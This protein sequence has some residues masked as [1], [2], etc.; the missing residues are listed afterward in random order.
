MV[1]RLLFSCSI[2][3]LSFS[4][5]ATEVK[6]SSDAKVSPVDIVNQMEANGSHTGFRRNH[7]KGLCVEGIFK[8]TKEAR[9]LSSSNIFSA[10]A[11]EVIGRFSNPGPNPNSPDNAPMP[12]GFAMQFRP[13]KGASSNMSMLD[14]PLFSVNTPEAFLEL[15][16][17]KTP[18]QVAAFKEKHPE[19]AP[20]FAFIKDFGVPQSYATVD[21][22]S[23]H[24]FKFTNKK[25]KE[26]FVR[27][28]FISD[29]GNHFL[30]VDQAK[31]KSA[32]FL[33]KTL[34]EE[35]KKG[36]VTWKMEAILAKDGDSLTD[37]TVE[38]KGEHKKV[39]LGM[40][41]IKKTSGNGSSNCDL[42]NYDPNNLAEGIAPSDDQILR[43]RSPAYAI[44]FGK[45]VSE[46]A[47][48]KQ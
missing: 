20:F 13:S 12:R 8:G 45:R 24:A 36:P 9:E 47:Q 19:S 5:F 30:T 39:Q 26:Q 46:Q 37:P 43:F 29:Q 41:T 34:E 42:I 31:A 23:L 6:S 32:D 22:H 7:A 28:N 25:G 44:S 17:V 2:G 3:L 4:V 11:V 48:K 33:S 14:V 27:W 38:W 16:K 40:L 35:L 15:L 18:E 21:Y 1:S 10:S